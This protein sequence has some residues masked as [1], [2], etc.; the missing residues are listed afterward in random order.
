MKNTMLLLFSLLLVCQMGLAQSEVSGTVIG[1][2][3]SPA[4]FV[5]V[6]L[7][8]AADQSLAKGVATDMDGKFTIKQIEDGQYTLKVTLIG[9]KDYTVELDFPTDNGKVLDIQLEQDVVILKEAVITGKVPLFIQKSDRVVVNIENNVIGLNNNLLDV[10]K[11]VPGMLVVN[12]RLQMA[13]Q[14]NVTVLINGKS[15]K[16]MDVQALLRNMPGDNVKSVEL[17]HQPGAEFEAEGTGPIVNI[18]LKKNN[19]LG[20]NGRIFTGY[21]RGTVDGFVS[22]LSLS[23]YKGNLNINGNVGFNEYVQY[24]GLNIQ[25]D[26]NGDSYDQE[27]FDPNNPRVFNTGLAL[28][29]EPTSQHRFGFDGWYNHSN[30]NKVVRNSTLIDFA[31]AGE[32]DL[33][34]NSNNSVEDEQRVLSLNPNYTFL[35]DTA[36]QKIDFDVSY[37]AFINKGF[38]EQISQEFNVGDFIAG[39]RY[40]TAGDTRIFSSKL[41]Y[42]KPLS[43]ALNLQFGGRFSTAR[44]DNDLQSLLQDKDAG[45]FENDPTQTNRFIYDEDIAAGYAKLGFKKNKW[46]GTVGLRYEHSNSI[47]NSVTLDSL[48]N[49][50]ISKLFPSF[51]LMRNLTS[52]LDAT[53]A[54]SYRIER[55]NY[56]AL[57]PFVY[58][59][60]PFTYEQGNPLLQPTMAHSMKFN[61]AFERQPFFNIEYKTMNNP[62]VEVTEQND[63]TGEAY[64][65]VVNLQSLNTF[66]TSFFFPLDFIPGIS[67]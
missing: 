66:H 13:G 63:D 49:R 5:T 8:H 15:T 46:S 25:R 47:G 17:I 22:N 54:Y 50:K 24:R 16:Y 14:A 30:L 35:I 62:M 12:D 27:T 60:D 26:V 6:A 39:R 28:N 51:S 41:D 11:R 44:L 23:H 20:T 61:L 38:T 2:D 52:A 37:A 10:M 64:T 65:T 42:Y 57:N 1:E 9:S 33:N 58:Y 55:P 31:D 29:W 18:I 32:T 34:I 7:Y 21:E 48:V 53:F 40:L 67:G 45:V 59:W 19:L 43:K 4:L 56:A 3:E 36:G